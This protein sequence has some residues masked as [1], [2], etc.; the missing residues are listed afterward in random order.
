MESTHSNAIIERK[1]SK[2]EIESSKQSTVE[3]SQGPIFSAG[4]NQSEST[5]EGFS[6]VPEGPNN[7]SHTG[8]QEPSS[9]TNHSHDNDAEISEPVTQTNAQPSSLDPVDDKQNTQGILSIISGSSEPEISLPSPGSSPIQGSPVTSAFS[10]P[11]PSTSS[12][13][14]IPVQYGNSYTANT[15]NSNNGAINNDA[16]GGDTS[17]DDD[18]AN[19]DNANN[20]L[21][22][23]NNAGEDEDVINPQE[24]SIMS[25]WKS[26]NMK[27]SSLY[28]S[29]PKKTM[30]I[31]MIALVAITVMV[32]SL[33][34]SRACRSKIGQ[35]A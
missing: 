27:V 14:N 13:E 35:A 21:N 16:N 22:N 9:I 25:L 32:S 17:D 23:G 7:A 10:T 34:I 29:I 6:D 19:N 20:D 12:L 3:E 30:R 24:S 11:E 15:G 33:F 5:S 2:G 31:I 1:L 8:N 18:D 26:F 28:S 4:Q